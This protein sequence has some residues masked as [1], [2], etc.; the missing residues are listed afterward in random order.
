MPKPELI[1]LVSLIFSFV[2]MI[3]A[4]K[5]RVCFASSYLIILMIRP[6]LYYPFLEQIRFELLVAVLGLVVI[7]SSGDNLK[8]LSMKRS[9]ITRYMYFFLIVIFVSMLQ[10][11]DFNR[12]WDRVYIEV[13]PNI[14]LIMLLITSCKNK[15]DVKIFLWVFG[16]TTFFLG[17]EAVFR[18]L[19]GDVVNDAEGMLAFGYGVS[20]KGRT[21]GHTGLANYLLQGMPVLF[22]LSIA[23]KG[24]LEKLLGLALFA[25]CFYGVFVSGSR[26]GFVGLIVM[27]I[28]ISIF[29]KR[30]VV[31][32]I[33]GSVVMIGVSS[34]MGG[35]YLSRMSTILSHT[36]EVSAN[37]RTQGLIHGFE[38]MTRRPI[39]GVGPGCFPLAR[40][41][42]FG[43]SLWSHNHY[44]QLMGELGL[45]GTITWFLLAKHYIKKCWEMRKSLTVDPWVKSMLTAILVTSGVRL[46]LGMFTHSALNVIWLILAGI[47]II[48]ER[49]NVE[50][51]AKRNSLEEP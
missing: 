42:W 9:K 36:T 23:S 49:L 34:L 30:P 2:L 39:L 32:M 12:S 1:V 33:L 24:Q 31:T 20:E 17:Y 35:E 51:T 38:M 6:G 27:L 16:I 46:A 44:G 40:K 22:Y 37:S 41:A 28:M 7:F 4:F 25:F 29:T 8:F 14:L 48:F 10:A 43:W 5:Y 45:L 18:F 19:S 47:V 15:K 3:G 26:G 11:W 13:I 50:N 21:E